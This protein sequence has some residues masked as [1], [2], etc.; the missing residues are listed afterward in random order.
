MVCDRVWKESHLEQHE[1]KGVSP[2]YFFFAL[3]SKNL[4]TISKL[5]VKIDLCVLVAVN[6]FT[7]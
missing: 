5:L 7:L 2:V 4:Q 1:G 3:K 6:R